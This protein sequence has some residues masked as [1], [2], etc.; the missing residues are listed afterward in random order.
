MGLGGCAGSCAAGNVEPVPGVGARRGEEGGRGAL[1]GPVDPRAGKYMV[2]VTAASDQTQTP[3]VRSSTAGGTCGRHGGSGRG[4]PRRCRAGPWTRWRPTGRC[5]RRWTRPLDTQPSHRRSRRRRTTPA[6]RPAAPGRRLR[7]R[8]P[9]RRG[10]TVAGAPRSRNQGTE[11]PA[12]GFP[13]RWASLGALDPAAPWILLSRGSP[14]VVRGGVAP[15]LDC[16]C[17]RALHAT[18]RVRAARTRRSFPS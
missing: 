13:A 6:T 16:Q 3:R 10:Q 2:A 8:G 18:S 5:R 11:R 7:G 12:G 17:T 1:N 14:R 9:R 4:G 15:M